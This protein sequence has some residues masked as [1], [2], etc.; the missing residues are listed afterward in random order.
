MLANDPVIFSEEPQKMKIN[1][2]DP[3]KQKATNGGK[4]VKIEKKK[5]FLDR[6]IGAVFGND[7]VNTTNVGE[8]F[9]NDFAEPL[10]KRL[11]NNAVQGAL[12]KTSEA[13]Q[14]LLFG[15]VVNSVDGPTDYTSFSSPN[16][17]KPGGYRVMDRV[18]V[19]AFT[20][21]NKALECLAYLRQ[22]IQTFG[23]AGVLDYFEWINDN[24][25]QEIP[26]DYNM[27][28]KGWVDLSNVTISVDPNGFIINLPNPIGLKK[29]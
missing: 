12:K 15:H 17:V 13:T 2:Q 20:D 7:E 25:N 16:K 18:D 1:I 21:K 24:L 4:M 23:S 5:S 10:G 28:N 27:A 14:T 26:L 22:R 6:V 3:N 9:M 29:G 19:F 8:H 11:L